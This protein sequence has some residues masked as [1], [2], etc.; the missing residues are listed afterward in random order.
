MDA[1]K[2]LIYH[3]ILEI[4]WQVNVTEAEWTASE[5]IRVS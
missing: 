2:E 4:C 3:V 1:D 5:L